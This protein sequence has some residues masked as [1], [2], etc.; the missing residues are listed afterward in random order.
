MAYLNNSFVAFLI[1]S[2]KRFE[3]NG[4]V[5]YGTTSYAFC[6]SVFEVDFPA[7]MCEIVICVIIPVAIFKILSTFDGER[8]VVFFI[9][10]GLSRWQF[11]HLERD[12]PYS[13]DCDVT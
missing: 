11:D 5:R 7:A 8:Y 10:V 9:P 4:T 12:E 3:R 13:L 6:V 1:S 2:F